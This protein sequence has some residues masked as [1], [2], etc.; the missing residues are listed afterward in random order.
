MTELLTYNP[1]LPE[2]QDDPYPTYRALRETEPVHR[3][4]FLDLWFLTRYDDIDGLLRD[5]RFTSDR[6]LWNSLPGMDEGYVPSMVSVDPPD[7]TRL[8]RLVS[9][10][11]TPAV[12]ARIRPWA[13]EVV[14]RALEEAAVEGGLDLVEDLARPLPTAV[15]GR[16]LGVPVEDWPRSQRWARAMVLSVDPLAMPDADR[17]AA[18]RSAEEDFYEYIGGLVARRRLEPR[19]D[20]IS[21]LVAAEEKGDVL[22]ERELL[23]MLELLLVAAQETTVGLIGNGALALLRHPEQLA[24]LADRPALLDSAIEELLRF[25]SPM[26]LALRV[27]RE[28]VEVQ[29]REIQAGDMVVGLLG[30]ANRDP[31]HFADPERLDLARSPN[32]H[33]GFGRGIHFCLGAPLVRL[34]AQVA[35]GELVRR[36]PRMEL[37]SEPRRSETVLIRALSSLPLRLGAV[38]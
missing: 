16:L 35:L 26:Q 6:T 9:K 19:D 34:E 14:D 11:F 32:P 7:H 1:F 31:E 36:F 3:S 21:A 20:L 24:L 25:D 37:A 30:A 5:R 2:V 27:A 13:R 15:I 18:F 22:G 10:A 38:R 4:P 17:V 8:R 12:V 29:G 28:D 33:F 23:A